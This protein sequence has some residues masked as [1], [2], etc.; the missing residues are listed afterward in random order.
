M[1]VSTYSFLLLHS[2]SPLYVYTSFCFSIHQLMD[3]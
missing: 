3:I 2:S 1:Y